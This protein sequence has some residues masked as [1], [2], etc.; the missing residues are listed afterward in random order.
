MTLGEPTTDQVL[1]FCAREPVERVFLE[2]VARRNLG[3]FVAKIQDDGALAALC[4][5]GANIVPSGEGC[6][7]FARAA[8]EGQSRMIIGEQG[9]VTALW[10]AARKLS[11]IHI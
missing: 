8:A 11:L 3:R 9:A 7:D 10:E 5:V 4:H 2:D 6:E 1:E